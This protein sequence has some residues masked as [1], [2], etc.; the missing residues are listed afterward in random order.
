M[1]TDR[2]YHGNPLA[3]VLGA[4]DLSTEQMQRFANWTNLSETT[5][6]LQPSDP[7]ADYAVRI[8]TPSVEL[9][10]AG[11]PTLGSARVWLDAGGTPADPGRIVQECGAGLIP[12]ERGDRHLAFRAPPLVRSGPL[13]TEEL[14]RFATQ[15]GIDPAAVVDGAW[16]DNGPGW[17]GLLLSDA[18]AVLAVE[19]AAVDAKIGVVGPYLGVVGPYADADDAAAHT[20]TAASGGPAFE[21]RAFFSANGSPAEDPVTGS[22][23]AS[24]AQWLV[25]SGRAT[26][27]Y[28]VAQGRAL[29]P[30]RAGAD[31]R[32][33]RRGDLGRGAGRHLHH[34]HRRPLTAQAAVTR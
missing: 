20:P 15:L 24:L 34:R 17:A 23:N 7:Q 30:V 18:D 12:I 5:F 22:L 14:T 11:H 1:F 32:R 25:A 6:L 28:E 31:H 3:V 2:P 8:F 29:G 19:L 9:P 27:P 10:F 16:V 13:T 21:V 4:D 26:P 33:R